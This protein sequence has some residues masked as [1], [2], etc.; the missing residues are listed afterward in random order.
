MLA[1]IIRV[2]YI[3][4]ATLVALYALYKFDTTIGN[5]KFLDKLSYVGSYITLIG[6]IVTIGEMLASAFL[7]RAAEKE[8]SKLKEKVSQLEKNIIIKDCINLINETNAALSNEEYLATLNKLLDLRLTIAPI[9]EYIGSNEAISEEFNELESLIYSINKRN[10]GAKKILITKKT[11][12]IKTKLEN[13]TN[14]SLKQETDNQLN[15]SKTASQL[16]FFIQ[17]FS[18]AYFLCLIIYSL[19]Q[20]KDFI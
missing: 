4:I 1:K 7:E 5:G 6:F 15:S 3:L 18:I 8:K 9:K 12:G 11:L 14:H 16:I 20:G 10:K 2:I 19:Y 17:I 13:V